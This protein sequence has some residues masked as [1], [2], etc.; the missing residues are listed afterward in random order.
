MP[1]PRKCRL[2]EQVPEYTYF[3][4]TGIPLKILQE[5]TITLEELE[6]L[7]LKDVEGLDQE[8]CAQRMEVSRP[9]FHRIL[10]TGRSKVAEAL[11]HGKAI[12][13]E[14]G[15]YSMAQRLFKCR[16]CGHQWELPFGTG[17]CGIHL[18]C[19]ACQSKNLH[20][21]D[22]DGHGCGCKPWGR[23]GR[24]HHQAKA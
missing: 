7:R 6:A 20:R 15:T 17:Q 16:D 1:R 18:N 23:K 21:I 13:I 10:T 24:G 22:N 19:P 5:V 12:K 11:V 2:I 3:K 9:T 8:D 14:G 4:P